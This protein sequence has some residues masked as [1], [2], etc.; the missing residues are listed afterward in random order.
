MRW[1]WELWPWN[2]SN[3]L[4]QL[5]WMFCVSKEVFGCIFRRVVVE[6][7]WVRDWPRTEM[8]T[9]SPWTKHTMSYHK[10][11]TSIL[12]SL[13]KDYIEEGRTDIYKWGET[14][15]TRRRG[16]HGWAYAFKKRFIDKSVSGPASLYFYCGALRHSHSVDQ[17]FY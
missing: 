8:A 11:S 12:S 13:D 14:R 7:I 9:S 17:I 16:M 5:F 10:S 1:N 15:S 4:K 6:T 2:F 3:V